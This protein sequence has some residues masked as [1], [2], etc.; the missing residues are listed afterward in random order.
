MVYGILYIYRITTGG[1]GYPGHSIVIEKDAF[2][3]DTDQDVIEILKLL[4]EKIE[5]SMND[6]YSGI[7]CYN[8]SKFYNC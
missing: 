4:G 6:G 5:E 8:I 3:F 2:R 7:R 1:T